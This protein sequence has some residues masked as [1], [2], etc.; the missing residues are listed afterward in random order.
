MACCF[1]LLSKAFAQNVLGIDFGS[2]FIKLAV[3]QRSAGVQVWFPDI[4]LHELNSL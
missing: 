2:E 3:V 4:L 1:T